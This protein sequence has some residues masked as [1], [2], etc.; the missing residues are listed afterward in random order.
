ML[1]L[2]PSAVSLL[3]QAP[4]C[5]CPMVSYDTQDSA[6]RTSRSRG[7]FQTDG[8]LRPPFLEVTAVILSLDHL[9][10]VRHELFSYA[11]LDL[12]EN[13]IG[14]VFPEDLEPQL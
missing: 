9:C 6:C 10:T 7:G 2:E 13:Y 8:S 5:L 1:M 12:K 11:A 3:Q 4:C 14:F